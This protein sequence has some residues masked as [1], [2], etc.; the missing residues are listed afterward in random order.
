MNIDSISEYL[1]KEFKAID[2]TI[3]K[4]STKLTNEFVKDNKVSEKT[5]NDMIAV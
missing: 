5:I 3:N 2:E 4:T 1:V